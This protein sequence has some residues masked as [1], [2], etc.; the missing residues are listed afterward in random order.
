MPANSVT[1]FPK[2]TMI[3][4]IIMKKVTRNP[5][6]SRIRSLRPLPVTA[7]IRAAISW[8]TMSATVTGISV[9]NSVW[10]NC[11]P[12]AE[13]VKMPLA[14]LSTLAVMNPGPTTAKNSKNRI[15]QRFRNLMVGTQKDRHQRPNRIYAERKSEQAKGLQLRAQQAD[16]VIRGDHT[17]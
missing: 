3:R 1:T 14:S 5:N 10:P 11:A 16:Y 8:I 13:Y 12:A 6:S 7:P 2:L 15:F 9:H 17:G 4:P